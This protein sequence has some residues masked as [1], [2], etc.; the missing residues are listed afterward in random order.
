MTIYSIEVMH[1]SLLR[2]VFKLDYSFS[3]KVFAKVLH[4][5]IKNEYGKDVPIDEEE[6][7][8]PLDQD[9]ILMFDN[10]FE[11]FSLERT[12]V[13]LPKENKKRP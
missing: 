8:E 13:K 5:L 12:K 4:S 7:N 9:Y 3:Y 6:L 1:K 10:I 2:V 11:E